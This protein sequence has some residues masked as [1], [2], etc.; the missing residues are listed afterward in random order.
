MKLYKTKKGNLLQTTD[1]F[2]KVK[3]DW[4]TIVNNDWLESYLASLI[5]RKPLSE[6]EK[7]D[8]LSAE[9]ILPPIGTQEVWAAGV[10]YLQSRDAR[11]EESQE[12]GGASLY[13]KVYDAERPELFFKSTAARV[14]G[15]LKEVY[16]RTDSTW[17]VPEPEL[18]LFINSNG[19]IQ[20]YT[21]GNDMSSRSIEG[22]N[23]LYLPQA[24]IYEKS[25]A[26][27]P[28]L[29]VSEQPID[30]EA[31]IRMK[32]IRNG[33]VAFEDETTVSRIKR[34]LTELSGFLYRELDFPVGCY[35]MTGTCLV[36]PPTFTLQAG[37]VVEMSI[38]H[39][40]TMV[41]TIN[42]NPKHQRA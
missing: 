31:A 42:L 22:E 6:A 35:L 5:T 25:A 41:N 11:M 24:K 37:D 32:I 40:G 16:I 10:T 30:K 20:G 15:H 12:S 33:E 7:N 1:G 26:L 17:D 27:G 39:I 9:N 38:D 3:G 14:S 4:D 29:F 23:A 28:C 36:P 19:N 21:I 2:F 8:W 13:D 34:S 18:A